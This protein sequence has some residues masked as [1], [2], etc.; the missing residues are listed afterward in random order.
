VSTIVAVTSVRFALA[1]ALLGWLTCTAEKRPLEFRDI[2]ELREPAQPRVSPDGSHVVFLLQQASIASNSSR[3]SVWIV[4]RGA[5]ARRLLDEAPLGP[6]EWTADGAALIVRLPRPGKAAFWRVPLD[7]GAPAPL[8]EHKDPIASAWWSPDRSRL[9]FI[10]MEGA[11]SEE[12]KRIE[13]EGVI[14]DEHVHGIRSFTRGNWTRPPKAVLW[15][16]QSGGGDARRVTLPMSQ[17]GSISSIV[18]SPDASMAA[19]EYA[20]AQAATGFSTHLGI[21]HFDSAT[22]VPMRFQPLVTLNTANRGVSWLPDSRGVVF[23]RTGDPERYYVPRSTLH[24]VGIDG[25]GDI[26]VRGSG[27][28][29]YLGRTEVDGSGKDILVEYNNQS[30]TTLYRVPRRG[31]AAAPVV[32]GAE[33]LSSFNFTRD[34]RHA[35]CIRQS[36]TE[37]PEVALVDL[38]SGRVDV[39]TK[40]NPEFDRIALQPATERRWRNRYGNE[41]NGFLLLP[42]DFR[43]GRPVPLVVIQYAVSNKFTTQAQWMTSYPVQHLVHA[44][45]AVLLHNYPRE[46]GWK[47]GDFEGAALSQAYN[48]LASMEAAIDSLVRD[49]I[50]DPKRLGIAGWSFGAWLAELAITKT[51][52]FRAASAGEG[53]LNNAGQYWVTGSAQMQEYLDAFFGGP[54]FGEAYANYKRLSPALNAGRVHTPLLREYGSDVGVQSLEFYMALRR[55]G[56]PVEQVIYPGAPHVLQSPSQRMAS[57][58]RNLDWFRFWLQ[59]Y[60]APGKQEQY[61]RWRALISRSSSPEHSTHRKP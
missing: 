21:L 41:S 31:G 22:G 35:A 44:G 36:I 4:S 52:L 1:F 57:M 25:S 9:L 7:G 17:V 45:I 55:L 40:L 24:T 47:R 33:D 59:N 10:T 38:S 43:N 6:A 61:A 18:W 60:E 48:P 14:Y 54:P 28:W 32:A 2:I 50:A 51:D 8:F 5:P 37:P 56:K 29:F 27:P 15:L 53:G 34:R 49:G 20:P 46:L 12:R 16:W 13:Q 42:P 26:E 30:H 39:L 58:E 11:S 19:I 3:T 23:A